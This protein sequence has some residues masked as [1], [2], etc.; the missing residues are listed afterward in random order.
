MD[1]EAL[2][3]TEAHYDLHAGKHQSAEEALRARRDGEAAPLKQFHNKIKREMIYRFAWQ[4]DSLLD[5]AC[6]RG[7]DLQKWFDAGV[8]YVKGIDLSPREVEEA[9]RR[10][11]SEKALPRRQGAAL[12][13]EF[14]AS[15]ELGLSAWLEPREFDAVT[16]MFALHYFFASERTL[17]T[18]LGNVAR[19][20]KPGGYFFGTVASGRRVQETIKRSGRWPSLRL[21]MLA[22]DARWRGE[23]APFGCAY[24]CAIGDTVTQ[25]VQDANEGSLEYLVYA[26]PLAAV[27]AQ[28]GLTPL[29]DWGAPE[30]EGFFDEADRG[31]LLKHFQPKF[32]PTCDASLAQASSLFAA[33][34]FQK[35]AAPGAPTSAQ[36][37]EDMRPRASAAK[38][39]RDEGPPAA[40]PAPAPG[41]PGEAVG[42]GGAPMEE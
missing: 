33:F 4:A 41:L 9:Q 12:Q 42:D 35:G 21:K 36:L 38:R 13:A 37:P 10:Y 29:T 22:L 26:S 19:N 40:A 2:K 39:P 32:P 28:H 15:P 23:A 31:K 16:C 3:R 27:A 34:A 8:K 18:F 24:N 11:A 6:G 14:M 7:G 5:F 30:L 1:L 20:L 17:R 25:G